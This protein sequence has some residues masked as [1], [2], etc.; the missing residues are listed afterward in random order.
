M[1]GVEIKVAKLRGGTRGKLQLNQKPFMHTPWKFIKKLRKKNR[2]FECILYCKNKICLYVVIKY[3]DSILVFFIRLR[4]LMC[5][6]IEIFGK[7]CEITMR[8]M[9]AP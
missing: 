8:R 3:F 5:A 2:P 4:L 9:Q 1:R 6:T 7:N